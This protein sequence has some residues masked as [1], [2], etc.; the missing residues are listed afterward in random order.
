MEI[1][2]R[3]DMSMNDYLDEFCRTTSMKGLSRITK[4]D[5]KVLRVLWFI[6]VISFLGIAVYQITILVSAYLSY[7]TITNIGEG[8]LSD[9]S[10][11]EPPEVTVC[12][13]N[14]FTSRSKTVATQKRIPTIMEY[15]SEMVEFENCPS[16]DATETAKR[17]EITNELKYVG[18]YYQFIGKEMAKLVGHEKD[19]FVV[20]CEVLILKG[21]RLL[22]EPCADVVNV[23][24]LSKPDLLNCY[25]FKVNT[26][27]YPDNFYLGLSLT[28]Y[29]DN[30]PTMD[31]PPQF[32][33]EE[34]I[35]VRLSVDEPN[36]V[37][38]N[39]VNSLNLPPGRW[40]HVQVSQEHLNRLQEP[41]GSCHKDEYLCKFA[42]GKTKKYT[43][44]GC[45]SLCRERMILENCDC[46]DTNLLNI[47]SEINPELS[48]DKEYCE[49]LSLSSEEFL[50]KRNC[51]RFYRR[52]THI[53]NNCSF[54]CSEEIYALST[55]QSHWPKEYD[56]HKFHKE[57]IAGRP[58]EDKFIDAARWK[59]SPQ[60]ELARTNFLRFSVY[61][62]NYRYNI[63][64]EK[65][66]ISL[67]NF[68]SQ[69]GGALNLWSGITI[70][71]FMELID[72]IYQIIKDKLFPEPLQVSRGVMVS[73]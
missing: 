11:I 65:A 14:P 34:P 2:N 5:R 25:Q 72:L 29:L 46:I 50:Q 12:N 33:I 69:L 37:P 56:M 20:E 71:V 58:Y 53:C 45:S 52:S 73:S 38:F 36:T 31:Y 55:S 60:T 57:Y 24:S 44:R 68:M 70:I 35:G 59:Q 47:L 41:Y 21:F 3:K 8:V 13:L 64:T 4:S 48:N 51:A 7:S 49:D 27:K 23:Y 67:S 32:T 63:Y 17:H 62:G 40:T 10:G 18:G 22:P 39:N 54:P 19:M 61:H 15:M 66:K 30:F 1:D 43:I 16:C 6:A 26:S 42:T 9:R 28:L